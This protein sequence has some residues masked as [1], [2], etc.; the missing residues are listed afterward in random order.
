V[1]ETST[2][3]VAE[4]E[5]LRYVAAL[6]GDSIRGVDNSPSYNYS[7]SAMPNSK[8]AVVTM[9]AM[10]GG[11]GGWAF[12]Y[13]N[14]PITPT[15]NTLKLAIDED[16]AND[17]ERKHTTE[18]VAYLIIDPPTEVATEPSDTLQPDAYFALLAVRGK[19]D[20][21][22]AKDSTA[23]SSNPVPIAPRVERLVAVPVQK[24]T[25]VAIAELTDSQHEDEGQ[26]DFEKIVDL[27]EDLLPAWI[28]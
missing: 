26:A 12:L 3:G 8:A 27:L 19:D 13:G 22:V 1:L 7:Y 21:H 2:S 16:Q 28:R 20:Q 15:G 23:T 17:T 14:D 10:D 9:A 11:N 24:A 5:G 18:Q 4:I 25:D 6:G